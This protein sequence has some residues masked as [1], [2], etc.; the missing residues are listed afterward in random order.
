MTRFEQSL[1]VTL[2]YEGG[3]S[4]RSPMDDPGGRTM[5]GV[6]QKVYSAY[7]RENGMP[8]ADVKGIPEAHLKAIYKNEYWDMVNG[9][10][11]PVGIDLLAFDFAVHSGADRAA[12]ELQALLGVKVDGQIGT[13]TLNA[14]SEEDIIELIDAYADAR[15][16]FLKRL[17]NYSKNPG[18]VTRVANVRTMAFRHQ[19]GSTSNHKDLPKVFAPKAPEAD[20]QTIKTKPGIVA[21]L[22]SASVVAP[23]VTS[24]AEQL[25]PYVDDGPVGQ[26]VLVVVTGLTIVGGVFAAYNLLKPYLKQ[27]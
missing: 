22:G 4:D 19:R 14:L 13:N 25:K 1:P 3:F 17:K 11:L 26:V 6:T 23:A 21:V 16:K 9:D 7:L 5:K 27:A 15:L 10:R 8:F 12:R 20:V 24:A 18:W 2:A